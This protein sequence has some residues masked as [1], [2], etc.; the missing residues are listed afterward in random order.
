MRMFSVATDEFVD[1]G[2]GQLR[3]LRAHSVNRVCTEGGLVFEDVA[4]SAFEIPCDL[5]ILALGFEGPARK[6][7]IEQ[8]KLALDERGNVSRDSNWETSALGVY[9]CGDMARGQSLIVWAIAEGRTVAAAVDR[10]LM[11]E[12]LLPAPLGL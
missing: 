9:A 7:M 4:G 12:S 8:F 11:G 6:G 3:G 1:D 10:Y 5:V 2:R